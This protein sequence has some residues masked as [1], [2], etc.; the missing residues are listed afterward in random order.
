MPLASPL[1]KHMVN[2]MMRLCTIL[3][4]TGN[5]QPCPGGRGQQEKSCEPSRQMENPG[6]KKRKGEKEGRAVQVEEQHGQDHQS[7]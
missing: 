5:H 1:A 6:R 2:E 3:R 7:H 4:L